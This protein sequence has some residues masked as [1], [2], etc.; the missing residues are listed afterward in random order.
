MIQAIVTVEYLELNTAP[1]LDRSY[2]RKIFNVQVTMSYLYCIMSCLNCS[3]CYLYCTSCMITRRP[4]VNNRFTNFI[5]TSLLSISSIIY[6]TNN[7]SK[8][9]EYL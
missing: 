4:V 2:F 1:N 3:M 7:N 6:I 5:I 8:V 9:L